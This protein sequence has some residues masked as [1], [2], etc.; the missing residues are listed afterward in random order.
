MHGWWQGGDEPVRRVEDDVCDGH[1]DLHV[2]L[3][4]GKEYDTEHEHDGAGE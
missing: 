4:I 3:G 2:Q 1:S